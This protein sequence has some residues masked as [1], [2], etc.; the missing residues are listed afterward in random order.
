MR[1]YYGGFES[2]CHA[3]MDTG[4]KYWWST[5]NRVTNLFCGAGG[6]FQKESNIKINLKVWVLSTR[7]SNWERLVCAKAYRHT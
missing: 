5:E 3:M 4:L 7:E 6:K 2:C 1:K